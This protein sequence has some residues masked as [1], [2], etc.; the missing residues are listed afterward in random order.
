MR[1]DV[2][3]INKSHIGSSI[4]PRK[5]QPVKGQINRDFVSIPH[6]V[7]QDSSPQIRLSISNLIPDQQPV[8]KEVNI[9]RT[10]VLLLFLSQLAIGCAAHIDHKASSGEQPSFTFICKNG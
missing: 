3:H 4:D 9:T 10:A 5:K 8:C 1:S 2:Y 6:S 7:L